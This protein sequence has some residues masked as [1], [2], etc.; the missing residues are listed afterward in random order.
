ML[1]VCMCREG[2]AGLDVLEV[3][4]C[5]VGLCWRRSARGVSDGVSTR[6][7]EGGPVSFSAP[8]ETLGRV[9]PRRD[10]HAIIRSGVGVGKW[11]SGSYLHR[12]AILTM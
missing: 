4:P 6:V 3:S 1:T 5:L 9:F 12:A 10:R 11:G 7:C 2:S 8:P